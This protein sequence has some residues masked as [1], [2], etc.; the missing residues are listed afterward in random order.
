MVFKGRD[1]KTVW[2][3][4]L[5]EER[6]KQDDNYVHLGILLTNDGKIDGEIARHINK[7]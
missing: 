5:G 4:S 7:V 6:I 1:E 2:H 3:I